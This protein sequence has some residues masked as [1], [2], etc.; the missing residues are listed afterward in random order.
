MKAATRRCQ[1]RLFVIL[2][3]TSTVGGC[4]GVIERSI[5]AVVSPAAAGNIQWIPYSGLA[6]LAQLVFTLV[7]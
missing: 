5:D 4:L 7:N 6:A 2:L 3:A 1:A